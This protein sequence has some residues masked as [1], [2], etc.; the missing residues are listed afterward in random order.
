MIGLLARLLRRAPP[1]GK[2]LG[3]AGE[4]LAARHLRRL[5]YRVR[6]RNLVTAAGEA[7]LVCDAP[8]RRTLVIVEVKTRLTGAEPGRRRIP[9]ERNMTYDKRRRLIRI[10]HAV[11][12]RLRAAG[13]PLRVDLVAIDWHTRGRPEVRHY[14]DAARS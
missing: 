6:A 7:D 5:G 11:S 1:T 14:P 12:K 10:A 3:D 8:D 4:R 9:P 13:R 2:A